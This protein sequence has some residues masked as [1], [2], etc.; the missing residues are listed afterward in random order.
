M[1]ISPREATV[2]SSSHIVSCDCVSR[3]NRAGSTSC[4]A[5][6]ARVGASLPAAA[7]YEMTD[8]KWRVEHKLHKNLG[9]YPRNLTNRVCGIILRPCTLDTSQTTHVAERVHL[10]IVEV[11]SGNN[12]KMQ[13]PVYCYTAI[14]HGFTSYPIGE[15]VVIRRV[16]SQRQEAFKLSHK[17]ICRVVLETL[18][19][20][21]AQ[22]LVEFQIKLPRTRPHWFASLLRPPGPPIQLT[23]RGRLKLSILRSRSKQ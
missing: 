11:A 6:C 8:M 7:V 21:R 4:R 10:R 16:C 13:H 19:V 15:P 9:I 17:G 1:P 2:A 14:P 18:N 23:G 20:S 12:Q 3:L 5:S 22:H